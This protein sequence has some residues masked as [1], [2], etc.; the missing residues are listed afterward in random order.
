MGSKHHI[1]FTPGG[2]GNNFFRYFYISAIHNTLIHAVT[3]PLTFAHR[4]VVAPG[5]KHFSHSLAADGFA[6]LENVVLSAAELHLAADAANT[7]RT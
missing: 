7:R 5:C 3:E 4:P 1:N 6:A 2:L